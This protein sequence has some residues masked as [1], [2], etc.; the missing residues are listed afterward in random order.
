VIGRQLTHLPRP[1]FPQTHPIKINVAERSGKYV[2]EED[3]L[4]ALKARVVSNALG[5]YKVL[6]ESIVVQ[7]SKVAP[8][9]GNL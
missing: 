6:I 2:F 4:P 1:S 9:I 8:S 3:S 5:A 7:T